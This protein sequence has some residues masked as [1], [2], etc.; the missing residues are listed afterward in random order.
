MTATR[1]NQAISVARLN[2]GTVSTFSNQLA[3]KTE[4]FAANE[5][6]SVLLENN[7]VSMSYD[8][9]LSLAS[10]EHSNGTLTVK[11]YGNKD[12]YYHTTVTV[13]YR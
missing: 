10:W 7:G 1:L 8:N 13:L 12:D 11:L 9:H 5:V 2:L 6:L 4:S 3:T